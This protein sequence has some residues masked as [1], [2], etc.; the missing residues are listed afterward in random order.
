MSQ[1]APHLAFVAPARNRSALSTLII[2]YALIEAAYYVAR[3]AT[4]LFV[5]L[6]GELIGYPALIDGFDWGQN[7][8]GLLIELTSFSFLIGATVF[9][10]W[11]HHSRSGWSLL[12][13]LT[14]FGPTIAKVTTGC[15]LVFVATELAPPFYSY[16]GAQF[17]WLR[18]VLLPLS[19]AALLIQVTAEELLYRGYLQ[20]QLAARFENPII[21]MVAVN[22]LFGIA[23]FDRNAD[24]VYALQYVAWA[25]VFGMAASDLT[26]RTG[27][28]AAAIGYH[29]ANNLFA[30]M[31]WAEEGVDSGLA[32][33]LFPAFDAHSDEG[34]A[35]PWFDLYYASELAMPVVLWLAARIV[36][37]R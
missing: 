27:S 36:I 37:R 16:E 9:I 28:L 32:L 33:L 26:A 14:D 34:M 10:T 8:P 12:G 6:L 22:L 29:L 35:L 5:T 20:Q 11:A 19:I 3:G 1:Y 21:W 7:Y 13:D 25:F 31:F 30:F 15:L 2:G 23:H 18:L 4:G 17:Q 24:L